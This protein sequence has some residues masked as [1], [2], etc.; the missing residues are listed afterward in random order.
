MPDRPADFRCP[1]CRAFYKLVRV[2]ADKV[3]PIEQLACCACG[4][5]LQARE[6]RYI[7]KYFLADEP[8]LE[9]MR[10]WAG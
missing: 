1:N 4:E 3:E 8:R 6:G 7:C 9:P 2:E 5:P 10:Q